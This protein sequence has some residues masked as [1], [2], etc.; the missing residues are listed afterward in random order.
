MIAPYLTI[1]YRSL[2]RHKAYTAINLFGLTIGLASCLVILIFVREE[3]S[4]DAWL[5]DSDRVYQVE[6]QL[7]APDEPPAF[8]Q[9]TF[10]P[11]ADGL[12]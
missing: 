1:A 4:Y 12:R 6:S 7:V 9:T 3:L 10:Y 2:A 5:P 8:Q 11:V